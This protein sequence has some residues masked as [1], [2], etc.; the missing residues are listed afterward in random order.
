[1][2][3]FVA[4]QHGVGKTF[5]LSSLCP[6][7]NIEFHS[8]SELIM[9]Y[10]GAANWSEHRV[11]SDFDENQEALV[12]A[13]RE[14]NR[15]DKQV[16]VDGHFVLRKSPTLFESIGIDIFKKFNLDGVVLMEESPDLILQRLHSRADGSAYWTYDDVL[17]LSDKERRHAEFVCGEIGI[18]LIKLK[19]ASE[20]SMKEA[21]LELFSG[22]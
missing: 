14:I 4:G 18:P 2:L 10:R 3:V 13:L 11:V 20:F 8:A 5:L 9:K 22:Y 19:S 12:C 15:K 21:L 17:S 7:M 6:S 1:M 16:V